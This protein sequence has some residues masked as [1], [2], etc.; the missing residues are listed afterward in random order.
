M[1][2][3]CLTVSDLNS[4][5]EPLR[6]LHL[7]WDGGLGGVQRYVL[8]VVGAPHWRRIQ[9]GVCFFAQPGAVLAEGMIPNVPC[10]ALGLKRGWDFLGARRLDGIV[11]KFDP[12]VIHCH[13]DT[14]AFGLR[15][16]RFAQRRLVYTEHGDTIMRTER[17]WFTQRMWRY[18]GSS[19]D[20]ILLN[21]EFVKRDFLA[22]FP[23]LEKSCRVFPNPLIEQWNGPRNPPKPGEPPRVGVFGRMV[24]QKG[25]DWMLTVAQT[26]CANVPDL[27]VEFFGDGPLRAELEAKRD[28]LNLQRRVVFHGFV[29]DPLARMAEMTCT[30][31]PSRIE[32]FG[33][34]ALEAQGA[35]VPV[36]G[37]SESGVAEIV[38]D[39][40][41]GCV[42]PYGDLKAMA[43]AIEEI[44]GAPEMAVK[45]GIAA[46]KRARTVFSLK[47]HVENLERM[48]SAERSIALF[49]G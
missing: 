32:P 26:I 4:A 34:V 36:V 42:V 7:L 28:A 20:A 48:Y 8:K 47:V 2:N 31:V 41:T 44:V 33:L 12:H 9:H 1:T 21:S 10:W 11:K 15:I 27:R 45:M 3:R 30:A 14:P 17:S 43:T 29:N 35:G 23:W 22:R 18:S 49:R 19:W 16:H 13:C 37:F 40:E 38:V 46:R 5:D 24:Q 6:V 39:G 25:M